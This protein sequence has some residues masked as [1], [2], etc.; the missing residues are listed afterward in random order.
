MDVID[1]AAGSGDAVC[2]QAQTDTAFD[3]GKCSE[4]I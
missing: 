3:G 2:G 4:P 1:D